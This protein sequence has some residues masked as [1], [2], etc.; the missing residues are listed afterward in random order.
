[1]ELNIQRGD[2]RNEDEQP[3]RLG[4]N[5]KGFFIFDTGKAGRGT[6]FFSIDQP[7]SG[8]PELFN[9]RDRP[10]REENEAGSGR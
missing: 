10:D 7:V 5:P 4:R 2:E 8:Q 6:A 1:M 3:R 9:S